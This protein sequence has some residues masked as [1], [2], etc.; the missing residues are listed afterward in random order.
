MPEILT[1]I[2]PLSL[3]NENLSETDG[4]STDRSI[5]SIN[6]IPST[7]REHIVANS[8]R[9]EKNPMHNGRI[10]KTRKFNSR[11]SQKKVALK[12]GKT[13]VLDSCLEEESQ[14]RKEVAN[15]SREVETLQQCLAATL[16]NRLRAYWNNSIAYQRATLHLVHWIAYCT[17]PATPPPKITA[18]PF[19]LTL[20]KALN[21][22]KR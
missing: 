5:T 1:I 12:V 3:T 13:L 17:L 10:K 16:G 8:I 11:R 21:I 7:S 9:C 19:G 22:V 4:V 20:E 2:P 15:L 6:G 18:F 14:L